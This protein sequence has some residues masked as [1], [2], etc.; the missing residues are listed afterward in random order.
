MEEALPLL[1]TH[2]GIGIAEDEADGGEEVALSGAIAADDDVG[3]G[4]E[5]LNDDLFFV[6]AR[7]VSDGMRASIETDADDA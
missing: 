6:A 4:G 3:L 5:G 7:G 1:A 2:L